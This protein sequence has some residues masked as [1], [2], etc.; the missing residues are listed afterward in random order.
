MASTALPPPAEEPGARPYGGVGWRLLE[1]LVGALP[2]SGSGA[3]GPGAGGPGPGGGSSGGGD[4]SGD[5]TWH[6]YGTT[7]AGEGIVLSLASTQERPTGRAMAEALLAGEEHAGLGRSVRRHL[8]PADGQTVPGIDPLSDWAD[9]AAATANELGTLDGRVEAVELPWG[10]GGALYL[11]ARGAPACLAWHDDAFAVVDVPDGLDQVLVTYEESAR[12]REV[13]ETAEGLLAAPDGAPRRSE[14]WLEWFGF[15]GDNTVSDHGSDALPDLPP[16]TAEVEIET[17]GLRGRLAVRAW[18]WVG[19]PLE[20]PVADPMWQSR[21]HR[22]IETY[23]EA[24]DVVPDVR[25]VPTVDAVDTGTA[26]VPFPGLRM[27]VWV[28]GTVSTA[29]EATD[30]LRH[31]VSVPFFRYEHDTFLEIDENAY[32]LARL[33]ADR[34]RHRGRVDLVGHSRGGLVARVA[35]DLLRHGSLEH[36]VPCRDDLRVRVL[37][38]GTPHAGTPVVNAGSRALT[39]LAGAARF[40]AA[41]LPDPASML[42]KYLLRFV[43]LPSGIKDMAVRSGFLRALAVTGAPPDLVSVGGDYRRG[44]IPESSGVRA[45]GRVR[46]LFEGRPNDLVVGVRSATAVGRGVSLDESCG[47]FGYAHRAEVRRELSAMLLSP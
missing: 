17:V 16:G 12:S 41:P 6:A 15:F 7:Q 3:D 25:A 24:A 35:A 8:T 20:R 39:A 37:T 9:A 22:D 18:R 26:L 11:D 40:G 44:P 23:S 43:R 5:T 42:L 47:H 31:D 33:L 1:N 45:L 2:T 38:L 28:H 29:L 34:L 32:D 27:L 30:V 21:L 14:T 36:G 4:S 10:V 19:A 46:G 13:R